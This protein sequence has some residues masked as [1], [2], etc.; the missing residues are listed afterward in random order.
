MVNMVYVFSVQ[1][2]N[3]RS[4]IVQYVEIVICTGQSCLLRI[5]APELSFVQSVSSFH[6][7]TT[8]LHTPRTIKSVLQ[9][10]TDIAEAPSGMWK[11][12]KWKTF[13]VSPASGA[14]NGKKPSNHFLRF[15]AGKDERLLEVIFFFCG[16]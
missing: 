4:N 14:C 2:T 15:V 3:V 5:H 12:W 1:N 7:L 8:H 9:C 10:R 11:V 13:Q 6:P 16:M